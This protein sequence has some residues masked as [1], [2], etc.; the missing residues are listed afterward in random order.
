MVVDA[1]WW[2]CALGGGRARG[3]AAFSDARGGGRPQG[4]PT[5]SERISHA[6]REIETGVSRLLNGRSREQLDR[7]WEEDEFAL[8]ADTLND[9]AINPQH[10]VLPRRP[11]TLRHQLASLRHHMSMA[12]SENRHYFVQDVDTG[13]LCA[14]ANST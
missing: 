14:W 12:E 9:A 5:E 7:G 10:E 6:F 2:W 8:F 13:Q 3:S 11:P 4:W 1:W